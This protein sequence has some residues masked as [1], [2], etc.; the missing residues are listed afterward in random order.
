MLIQGHPLH[1]ERH[2]SPA[3]VYDKLI[4]KR[5][6]RMSLGAKV[7]FWLNAAPETILFYL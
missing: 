7:E 5:P 6:R 1:T 4:Y 3:L 2:V